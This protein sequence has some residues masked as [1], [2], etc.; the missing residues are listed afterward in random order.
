MSKQ[1]LPVGHQFSIK[2]K[3]FE[4]ISVS[5]KEDDGKLSDF[6]YEI[7]LASEVKLKAQAEIKAAEAERKEA[8]RRVRDKEKLIAA[9]FTKDEVEAMTDLQIVQNLKADKPV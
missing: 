7:Q 6:I 9:G 4:V 1:E 8:A 3:T 5:C 2:G